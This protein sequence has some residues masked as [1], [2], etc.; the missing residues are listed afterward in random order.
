M[1][2]GSVKVTFLSHHVLPWCSYWMSWSFLND[3]VLSSWCSYWIS[4]LTKFVDAHQYHS[5]FHCI[6]VHSREQPCSCGTCD[7]AFSLGIC[8]T[9]Q[10]HHSTSLLSVRHSQAAPHPFPSYTAGDQLKMH[11]RHLI[12]QTPQLNP[13][14]LQ[15]AQSMLLSYTG[16]NHLTQSLFS[17]KIQSLTQFLD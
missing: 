1:N 4:L 14:C 11:L 15:C 6:Q 10:H 7:K 16:Q 17:N 8:R 13:N 9:S 12:N 5:T 3:H 2:W